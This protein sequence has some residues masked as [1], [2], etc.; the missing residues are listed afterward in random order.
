MAL[1]KGDDGDDNI[2]EG[3]FVLLRVVGI[4][5]EVEEHGVGLFGLPLRN[6]M[7]STTHSQVDQRLEPVDE[8]SHLLALV[9]GTIG[10]QARQVERIHRPLITQEIAGHVHIAVVD[11][12]TVVLQ[13]S[14]KQAD[15]LGCDGSVLTVHN[16]TADFPLW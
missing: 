10:L 2:M 4:S 6:H 13:Q 12:D 16:I 9:P 8:T 1:M 7:S 11:Q 15:S 5:D 3:I 14:R